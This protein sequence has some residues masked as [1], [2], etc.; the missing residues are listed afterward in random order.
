MVEPHSIFVVPY[1]AAATH[2]TVIAE[3]PETEEQVRFLRASG[4]DTAQGCYF[5]RPVSADE[6]T[7]L[8][9]GGPFP[10]PDVASP[11]G[12]PVGHGRT[13]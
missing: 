3:G 7:L 11:L 10:R 6:L 9:R 8:L 13:R 1:A 4:C 2:A 5:S 12:E